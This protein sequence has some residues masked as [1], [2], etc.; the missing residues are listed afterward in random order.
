MTYGDKLSRATRPFRARRRRDQ[1]SPRL[2][3]RDLTLLRPRAAPAGP[4]VD[5]DRM[6]KREE[7]SAMR[8]RSGRTFAASCLAH[9]IGATLA[10]RAVAIELKADPVSS[11]NSIDEMLSA[12]NTEISTDAWRAELAERIQEVIDRKRS[13]VQGRETCLTAYVRILTAHYAEEEIRGKEAELVTAFLKSIKTESSE[14]ETVL[15]MKGGQI[16][17]KTQIC[18]YS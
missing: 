11:V 9:F 5:M 4:P 10:L 15:A 13:S 16:R 12:D 18:A 7:I 17:R 8:R 2:P 3:V 14:K 1:G 6:R